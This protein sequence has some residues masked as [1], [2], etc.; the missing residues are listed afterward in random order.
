MKIL[1]DQNISQR[2]LPRIASLTTDIDHVR[3]LGLTDFDDVEIFEFAKIN[4]I[5]AILTL[6]E[7]FYH[8]L[9]HRGA[10]PKIIWLRTGNISTAHLS[11]ILLRNISNILDFLENDSVDCLEIYR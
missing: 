5:P 3:H 6:D 2:L 7:D 9:L 10:P 8:I 11:E 1:V 4:D